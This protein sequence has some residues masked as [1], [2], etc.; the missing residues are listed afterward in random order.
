MLAIA[1]VVALA[2]LV[3][4]GWRWFA[5]W[6][7]L[8]SGAQRAFASPDAFHTWV[9]GLGVWAPAV[10]LLMVAAQVIVA[11]IP[12][13]IFP[14]VG[15]AAF[16]P[17]AGLALLMG[18]MLLGSACVFA[19]ARRWGRP[20][21]TRLVGEATFDRYAG[22]VS[23][24]GGLWLLLIFLLPLLPDD[25]V[26]AV[27]GL[28]RISFRRFLLLSAVGRLPG[29]AFAVFASAQ[30]LVAPAWVWLVAAL[31]IAGATALAWRYHAAL[32]A[33]LLRHASRTSAR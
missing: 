26:C 30:L 29:S 13:S 21:A 10:F 7:A 25:A 23:A 4:V 16:G 2:V 9:A 19:L 6:P 1:A 18:G 14:P 33:W 17:V 3:A 5:D 20:L 24:H 32:E 28:S 12:G 8:W 15:A 27:A 31:A 11:P 22:I